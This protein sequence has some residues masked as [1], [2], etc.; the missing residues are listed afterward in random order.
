LSTTADSVIVIAIDGPSGAGK[1]TLSQLVAR[2]LGFHLLD[3]GALYR[4]T[5]LSAIRQAVDLSN[6]DLVAEVAANLDVTFDVTGDAT[7]MLLAGDDVTLAIREE[8]VGMNASI[9]AAYPP[10]RAA[11][12][13]RQRDFAQSPGLVAD[14][15]DMGTTV[16]PRAQV[17]IFLTASAVARAGRRYRQLAE[18][19]VAVDMAELIKDIEARDERDTNRSSSPLKPAEDA[20]LLDS[21][22]LSIEQVLEVILTRVNSRLG[23]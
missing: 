6:Q 10:V 3:S 1:G 17:K 4:L 9:I 15:R 14:G 7:R 8:A 21:T 13:Q 19:G 5:A 16:F 23:A 12:L 18:K 11:L 2:R 22:S 20:Y